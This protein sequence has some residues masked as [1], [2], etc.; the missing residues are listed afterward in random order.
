[1]T[2]LFKALDA[3]D[4]RLKG[5]K[6]FLVGN[7]F[8]YADLSLFQTLI[9]FDPVYHVHFK[10]SYRTIES[11]PN[12]NRSVRHLYNKLGLKKFIHIEAIKAHYFGVDKHQNPEGII[13]QGPRS[14]WL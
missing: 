6:V 13:P 5:G 8:T 14:W 7:Q 4:D 9:R 3:L 2:A 11:Y 12:L 10:C 1:V